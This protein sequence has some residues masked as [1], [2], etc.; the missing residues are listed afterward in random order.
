M[1]VVSLDLGHR[2]VPEDPAESRVRHLAFVPRVGPPMI[3]L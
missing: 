1:F 2:F 3:V